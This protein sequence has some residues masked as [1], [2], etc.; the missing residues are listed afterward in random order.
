[1]TMRLYTPAIKAKAN[2]ISSLASLSTE[3]LSRITPLLEVPISVEKQLVETQVEK[4][5]KE[6]AEKLPDIP[7]Y[8]DPLGIESPMRQIAAFR[9]L[10]T[11]G[12]KIIP[13]ISL[14]RPLDLPAL[15]EVLSTHSLKLC[16]RVDQTDVEAF[17][18]TWDRL[19]HLSQLLGA[20]SRELDIIVDF[21]RLKPLQDVWHLR[22]LTVDFF[23]ARPRAVRIGDPIILASSA[24]D[25]V[26]EVEPDKTKAIP[27]QELGLWAAICFELAHLNVKFGDYG[28]VSPNFVFSGP[29]PNANAKIR[30]TAG[31]NIHYFRGHGL[32]KPS[33]F[34]QYH[35]I[36][37][38]V[39]DSGHYLGSEFS[40]G[41]LYIRRCADREDG[42]GNL[43]TWVRV[44][45]N[46]HAEL[47]TQQV[48]ALYESVQAISG[49]EEIR[50]L[51]TTV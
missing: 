12:R 36:A 18:E 49:E 46:H 11:I 38:R 14:D 22:D 5:V 9:A 43:A 50:E 42:P 13:T 48:G 35:D 24:L 32:Y 51:L 25:S 17:E 30:Y 3:A 33:R 10:A 1:M 20:D 8:F 31:A 26:A 6:T 16:I 34:D 37:K 47:T 39:T 44:D 4:S 21:K 15:R 27:R 41:D 2:D 28:V 19:E 40:V 23:A 45:T 7:F 29:N